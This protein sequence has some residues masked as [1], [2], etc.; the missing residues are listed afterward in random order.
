[1]STSTDK[2]AKPK[3]SRGVLAV[4]I[5]TWLALVLVVVEP[6]PMGFTISWSMYYLLFGPVIAVDLAAIVG[7]IICRSK[8]R[9]ISFVYLLMSLAVMVGVWYV[10]WFELRLR[11]HDISGD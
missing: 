3:S 7:F 10:T 8:R 1:M 9:E 11:W 6:V 2:I 5:L 4:K